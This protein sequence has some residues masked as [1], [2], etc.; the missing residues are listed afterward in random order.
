MQ[1]FKR[2]QP[3]WCFGMNP[4]PSGSFFPP[5]PCTLLRR[6]KPLFH[7]AA[8]H[9][10]IEVAVMSLCTGM[11]W[12]VTCQMGYLSISTQA[13]ICSKVRAVALGT[14]LPKQF[15]S[16]LWNQNRDFRYSRCSQHTRRLLCW[17]SQGRRAKRSSFSNFTK[18]MGMCPL[19]QEQVF[20]QKQFCFNY[21]LSQPDTTPS[22]K[23]QKPSEQK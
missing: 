9:T 8:L 18:M 1:N 6:F 16:V 21:T 4:Q 17:R 2:A 15:C 12:K 20:Y 14:K 22:F 3:P 19:Q 23:G 11:R 10:A 7:I 5:L 13:S